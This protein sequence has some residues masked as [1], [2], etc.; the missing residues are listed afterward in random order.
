[1]QGERRHG[2]ICC[3]KFALLGVATILSTGLVTPTL[4]L[5]D[6]DTAMLDGFGGAGDLHQ[7]ARGGVEK[8]KG[9]SATICMA[10]SVL[11]AGSGI[12][13]LFAYLRRC[14]GC[15]QF[16]EGFWAETPHSGKLAAELLCDIDEAMRCALAH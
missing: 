11:L 14:R 12:V 10:G 6:M 15:G 5:L 4:A 1:M 8:A 16:V 2:N 9:W 3:T 13:D 7:I